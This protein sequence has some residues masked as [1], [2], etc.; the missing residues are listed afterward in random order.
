MLYSRPQSKDLTMKRLV[1]LLLFLSTIAYAAQQIQH[2]SIGGRDVAVWKPAGVAP[3]SGYPLI[4]FSHGFGGCNTQSIFLMDAL[5]Q[6]G[7][8]VLAPN[9][10]DARCGSASQ[11]QQGRNPG[12][13]LQE[14]KGRRPQQPFGKA[15]EWS[16]QTYKDREDDIAAVLNAALRQKSFLDVAIDA[17]RVGIAGHSLGGYTALGVAGAWQSWKDPRIKAVLA[18]SPFCTPYIAHGDLPHLNVPV[19]YQGGTR[20]LG[21]TPTVKRL[22]GAYELSSAPKYYVEFDGAGHFAWTNLNKKYQSII[23]TYSL[24]F[25]NHYLKSTLVPD[26]LA[27]LIGNP[28]PKG[29]SFLRVNVK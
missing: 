26:S 19:M 2:T 1:V 5:A 27:P 16:D 22:N 17:N 23:G 10:K 4:V 20:D 25:F 28:P 21:I 3:D 18:L 9:H 24:A 14:R 6:A 15:E 29:V 12:K 13:L 8:L 7:Y 11:G